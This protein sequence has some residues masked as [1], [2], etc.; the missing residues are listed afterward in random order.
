MEPNAIVDMNNKLQQ[1][2][3]DEKREI[4]VI[5]EKLT[6]LIAEKD[7]AIITNVQTVGAVDVIHARAHVADAMKAVKPKI[8]EHGKIDMKQARHPLIPFDEV[9]ANDITLGDEYNAIVITGPNTG[10]KTV[11]LKMV[12]LCT[13]MAQAGLHV[14]ALD[15]CELALFERIY[16]DIGDEQ[17]IEQNLSTFSSHMTNIVDIVNN[18]NDRTLV[19]FDEIGAGTDPQEGAALAMSI[20]DYVIERNV[21]VIATTHYPELKA[22]GYE[23]D[24]VMN[25][26]VEF[27]VETLQP[28]Y[29]LFMGVPGRSNAFEISDR[30]GLTASIIDQAKAY[31]G[32]DSSNVENMI[33]ALE[34]S[35]K[36]AEKEIEEAHRIL[37][38]SENLR[39]ELDSEWRTF[40]QKRDRLF[41]RAE[42]EAKQAIDEARGEAERIVAEVREMKD[43]TAWKEHEWIERRKQLEEAQP[44]LVQEEKDRTETSGETK[45]LEVGDEIKH[46]LL[47]QQGQIIEKK[48][49][50]EF[51]IQMGAMRVT[52][53][54]KDLLLL[55]RV[56]REEPEAPVTHSVKTSTTVKPELDLRGERYDD[57]LHKLEQYIDDALLEGYHQ[58]TIIHGKG[59][60]ALR[61]GVENFIAT[62]PRIKSYRL[63][64]HNEGGSGVTVIEFG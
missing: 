32:V 1:A 18:V 30:L 17:S 64:A 31:L 8:N 58:V 60:G 36:E 2:V 37:E 52:A 48:A 21:R 45:D 46:K 9:V 7:E 10:G 51:V 4:D 44:E 24:G 61:K 63:G 50:G 39:R 20:L 27:N 43:Q 12:G 42:E 41:A 55:K 47:Q 14:P 49:K 26:S 53:K 56:R 22:Y 54:Q 15:G 33:E 34:R 25:A 59:T 35:R 29:R 16:A 57:A 11:T 38:E 6:E 13:L 23:R 5:L 40:L 28:T 3:M 62:H 19:L